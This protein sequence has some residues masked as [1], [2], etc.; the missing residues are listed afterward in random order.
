MRYLGITLLLAR[1]AQT[2]TITMATRTRRH[3][4]MIALQE[5]SCCLV[6]KNVKTRSLDERDPQNTAAISLYVRDTGKEGGIP[7]YFE[8][9]HN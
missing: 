8:T 4:K 7:E 5:A 9:Q 2:G 1:K 3:I 6:Q